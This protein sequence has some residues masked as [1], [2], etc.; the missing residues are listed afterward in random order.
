MV[1]EKKQLNIILLIVFIGFMGA[2]LPYTIFAPLFLNHTHSIDL[3]PANWNLSNRGLMLGIALAAYPFGQFFGSPLLGGLSDRYGRKFML[4]LSLSLSAI[5]HLLAAISLTIHSLSLLL[6]S[7]FFTGLMEGNIA[8][9][10]SMAGDFKHIRKEFSFGRIFA[11]GSMGY[12]LGPLLGGI[13]SDNKIY[14]AFSYALPFYVATFVALITVFLS[15]TQ[16]T[17]FEQNSNNIAL[18][19]RFNFYKRLKVLFSRR[20]L[21]NLLIVSI[22]FTFAVDIFYEFGPVYLTLLWQMSPS[23]IAIYNTTLCF[24]LILGSFNLASLSFFN[25][26]TMIII[27]MLITATAFGLMVL[28]QQVILTLFLFFLAGL[29]IA[30][31]STRLNVQISNNADKH[32]HGETIGNQFGLRML[33]DSIICLLGG[34]M[35]AHNALL[36]IFLSTLIAITAFIFYHRASKNF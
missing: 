1:E 19:Q 3:I 5:G 25:T 22:I 11:I 18:L 24:G 34:I 31:T 2:S 33:G 15:A 26:R 14:H 12:I 27:S 28:F 9:V 6:F 8:I 16:L 7:R 32:I 20:K 35:I 29:G 21:K 23:Q 36:P 4:I 13:I 30:G 17:V 10:Q